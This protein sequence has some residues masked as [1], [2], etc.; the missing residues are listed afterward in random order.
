M[1]LLIENSIDS[2]AED[3]YV[4]SSTKSQGVT[5]L[6]AKCG[7]DVKPVL[8]FLL[9]D[10]KK[11]SDFPSPESPEEVFMQL[12]NMAK[13]ILLD[14]SISFQDKWSF[15][16]MHAL[17]DS[18]TNIIFIDKAWADEKKLPLQPLQYAIPI[19]NIDDTKNSAGNIACNNP[20]NNMKGT[21]LHA[22]C[23]AIGME[24]K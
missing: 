21:A 2:K 17:L 19:F 7:R 9:E 1:P 13:E 5:L 8:N 3:D 22:E 16:P 15:I 18:G 11:F 12:V 4:S 6:E 14:V 20:T 23:Q 24:K 10:T